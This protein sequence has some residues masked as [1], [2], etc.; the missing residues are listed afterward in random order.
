MVDA[1]KMGQADL[2]GRAIALG[3][4]KHAD[5]FGKS[6]EERAQERYRKDPERAARELARVQ[7]GAGGGSTLGA[8]LGGGLGGGAGVRTGLISG[9]GWVAPLIGGIGGA[10]LGALGGHALGRRYARA[11]REAVEAFQ[12]GDPGPRP[13]L[14]GAL[15]GEPS[16]QPAVL[17]TLAGAKGLQVGQGPSI[18]L[19][20][21]GALRKLGIPPMVAHSAGAVLGAAGLATVSGRLMRQWLARMR[22]LGLAAQAQGAAA[23]EPKT[24]SVLWAEEAGRLLAGE[25][26]KEA[27]FGTLATDVGSKLLGFVGK[28]PRLTT[29]LGMG[30]AGS[31]VGAG[32]GGEGNRLGG[33]LAGG[34]LGAGAGVGLGH[35]GAKTIAERAPELAKTLKGVKPL[36]GEPSLATL[37]KATT[38]TKKGPSLMELAARSGKPLPTPPVSP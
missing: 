32:V 34:V 28:N 26:Q 14:V 38:P 10:A 17:A 16:L 15:A 24:A 8:F 36:V 1:E 22:T 21:V 19:H 27:S 2:A 4:Q 37:T 18:M 33:A 35:L 11:K 20:E 13:H 3:L 23:E 9:P 6:V 7:E 29:A 12:R 30:A 25:L 5:F 31:L